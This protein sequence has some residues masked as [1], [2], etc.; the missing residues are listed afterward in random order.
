RLFSPELILTLFGLIVL[1]YDMLVRRQE[2]GQAALTLVG[3]GLS[4]I[5]ALWV[6]GESAVLFSGMFVVDPFTTF[7]RIV[8]IITGGLILM[9]S[10]DYLRQRS[11]Y[12]GEFYSLLLFTIL[13][14]TLMAGSSDLIMVILSIEF[15]S[16]TSYILTG[17]LRGDIRSSEAS[18]KYFLYGSITT[19]AMVYGA[20]L[21]YGLS[22]HT[23]LAAIAQVLQS[24]DAAFGSNLRA[25]SLPA[26]MLLFTG[27]AFKIALVPFHQWSP[28]AYEGAPTPVTAFLS[29]GPKAVGFAML[30][31]VFLTAL[32]YADVEWTGVLIGVAIITMTLGNIVAIVQKDIKRLLAYSSIAQ[33]GFMLIGI[34]SLSA[35]GETGIDA[36]ASTLLYVFAYVFTNMGAFAIVIAIDNAEG[37]SA[38]TAYRGLIRRHPLMAVS[39]FVFFLSL[40][41]IPPTGGFIGKFSV[42]LSAVDARLYGLAAIGVVNG[43]ISV[44]YYF[45]VVKEMF[46][47][48]ETEAEPVRVGAWLQAA[49]VV[50]LVMTLVIG[51]YPEPFI[52]LANNAAQGLM[53]VGQ[54]LALR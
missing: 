23:N 20:S 17:W 2:R 52:E 10:V 22:G 44:V 42:F 45:G 9:G 18:V 4:L 34:A 48:G 12:R 41:G 46:F 13:S 24:P 35:A 7:F 38:I 8:S 43:V 37:S 25:F 40:V 28:D 30:V 49:L 16:I 21:L 39:M 26:A 36:V 3:L 50:S 19:A 33:A 32:P 29:I 47:L 5:A 31:R 54:L 14:M 11:S 1:S 27:F 53:G 51:L 15:L 6:R